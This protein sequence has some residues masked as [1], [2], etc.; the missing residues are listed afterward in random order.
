MG[1]R[2]HRKFTDHPCVHLAHETDMAVQGLLEGVQD[3]DIQCE[4]LAEI[5]ENLKKKGIVVDDEQLRDLIYNMK[6]PLA[7]AQKL[8]YRRQRPT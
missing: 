5:E 7:P 2:G 8:T 3:C 4:V 1:R 6:N